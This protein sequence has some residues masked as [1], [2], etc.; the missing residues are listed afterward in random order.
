MKS[1]IG[2]RREH[3]QFTLTK[4]LIIQHSIMNIPNQT[5]EIISVL[6]I[7]DKTLSDPLFSQQLKFLE[8]VF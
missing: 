5:T 3:N 2:V 7:I 8:N 6:W 4:D 1:E